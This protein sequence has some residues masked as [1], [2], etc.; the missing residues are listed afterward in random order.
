MLTLVR[1]SPDHPDF[2]ALCKLLDE[3][4]LKQYPDIQQNFMPHNVIDKQAHVILAYENDSKI[5]CGCFRPTKETGLAEI[6]RMYVKPEHRAKRVAT[7]I[8]AT[9]E[10]WAI[11]EGFEIA[12][13]ETGFL[14]V[15]ALALYTRCGYQR[16]PNY[17]PYTDITESIC[18]SKVLSPLL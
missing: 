17:P 6:K 5:G 16:I 2:Q 18:M 14:Q 4:L 13:L 7:W 10:Y 11:E 12:K 15:E 1:A 8:L 9:L 3:E